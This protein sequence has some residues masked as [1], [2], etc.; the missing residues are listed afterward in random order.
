MKVAA[1]DFGVHQRVVTIDP[2][3]HV[4]V[5]RADLWRED[6][7]AG[8]PLY[9]ARVGPQVEGLRPRYGLDVKHWATRRGSE[10]AIARDAANKPYG[11]PLI[12]LIEGQYI[13][14]D[15]Q[16]A[17]RVVEARTRWSFAFEIADPT[18]Q[19]VV[20]PGVTWI[21][22]WLGLGSTHG[23]EAIKI[24]SELS[25]ATAARAL[26]IPA[27]K[28]DSADALNMFLW[29]LSHHLAG[30]PRRF[31]TAAERAR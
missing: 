1:Q 15:P 31:K 28:G 5:L 27:P 17:I 10:M 16:S 11:G 6:E 7:A 22:G 23:R 30:L 21:A 8:P 4:G 12:V 26:G 18:V 25:A 14:Q 20:I 3:E 13:G 29:W 24:A 19:V 9:T 2:A